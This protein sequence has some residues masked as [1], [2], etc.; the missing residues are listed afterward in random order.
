VKTSVRE[1]E[2]SIE[3]ALSRTLSNDRSDD[4]GIMRTAKARQ[5]A[6]SCEEPGAQKLGLSV[7]VP[8]GGAIVRYLLQRLD[9]DAPEPVAAVQ[10]HADELETNFIDARTA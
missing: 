2:L 6:A 7:S 9:Q 3:L 10:V 4:C 5:Y 1:D 8:V